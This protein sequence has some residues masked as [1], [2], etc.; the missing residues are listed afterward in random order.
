MYSGSLQ[1]YSTSI[2]SSH[3]PISITVTPAAN[4]SVYNQT[5]ISDASNLQI[6]LVPLQ[7]L[8]K[9][10]LTANTQTYTGSLT[11][12]IKD[13]NQNTVYSGSATFWT[14]NVSVLIFPLSI[15]ATPNAT[16]SVY[17]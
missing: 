16:Y 13:V 6:T 4:Y 3:F 5:G 11:V 10:N 2:L 1:T 7:T 14:A 8:I 15:T 9:Y 17:T 12:L